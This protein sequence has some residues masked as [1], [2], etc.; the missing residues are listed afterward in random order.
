MM[1]VAKT[2]HGRIAFK[3]T[4]CQYGNIPIF[5]PKLRHVRR[6]MNLFLVQR[7]SRLLP[8]A[9]SYRIR[10]SKMGCHIVCRHKRR[11]RTDRPKLN[12]E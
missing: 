5:L 4:F 2:S 7:R 8:E 1:M 9:N 3:H 12:V 11:D 10:K 6:N